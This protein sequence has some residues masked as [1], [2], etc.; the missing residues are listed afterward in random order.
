MNIVARDYAYVPSIVD[1]V[2]GETVLLHVINGGLEQHEAVF[3]SLGD[4]LAWET[5]EAATI[6]APPGPT[7][8]VAAA[9]RLRRRP[10]RRR[11]R[12]ADRRDLDGAGGRVRGGRRLVRRLPH[13]GPLAE[14]DGRARSGSSAPT[15][16]PLGTPPALP[17]IGPAGDLTPVPAG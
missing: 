13:P 16:Q 12:R 4:Q 14:G 8:F 3:G 6:G 7:P 17:S 15:A 2:P 11:V 9:A 10:G 1:L 5:A